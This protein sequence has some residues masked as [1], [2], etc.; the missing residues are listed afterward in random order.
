MSAF[1]KWALW[2]FMVFLLSSIAIASIESE[3]NT[4]LG[5]SIIPEIKRATLNESGMSLTYETAAGTQP[6]VMSEQGVKLDL[7]P[8]HTPPKI[9]DSRNLFDFRNV[10][11][12]IAWP[13]LSVVLNNSYGT[14]DF[15]QTLDFTHRDFFDLDNHVNLSFNHVE[16]D[17]ILLP[18]FNASSHITIKGLSFS[19]FRI[20]KDGTD[21][22][23]CSLLSVSGSDV[24][25]SAPGFSVYSIT[26]GSIMPAI[27]ISMRVTAENASVNIT[28]AI[29]NNS[30]PTNISLGIGG[31]NILNYTGVLNTTTVFTNA[32]FASALNSLIASGC[33]CESCTLSNNNL[34]C[35]ISM[36]ATSET[37]G[38]LLFADLNITQDIQNAS[39]FHAVNYT[40]IDL[41]DYFY[42]Y[43]A[44]NL[45]YNYTGGK[46]LTVTIENGTVVL[47]A[48][49]TFNDVETAFNDTIVFTASDG[50]NV[51]ESNN[52]TIFVSRTITCGNGVI[53][54]GELCDSSV[55]C[56][57]GS[58]SGTCNACVPI[59]SGGG[60]GGTGVSRPPTI[61]ITPPEQPN[62][63]APR[64]PVIEKPKPAP[65]VEQPR[66]FTSVQIITP[67]IIVAP[68]CAIPNSIYW[69]AMLITAIV[70]ILTAVMIFFTRQRVFVLAALIMGALAIA[71]MVLTEGVCVR[72]SNLWILIAGATIVALASLLRKRPPMPTV[73]EPSTQEV[74]AKAVPEHAELIEPKRPVPIR[75]PVL[76]MPPK[77]QPTKQELDTFL[78]KAPVEIIKKQPPMPKVPELSAEEAMAKVDK[79]YADMLTQ[80]KRSHMQKLLDI[81]GRKEADVEELDTLLKEDNAKLEKF[82]EEAPKKQDIAQPIKKPPITRTQKELREINERLKKLKYTPPHVRKAK[83]RQIIDHVMTRLKAKLSKEDHQLSQ[84][85]TKIERRM[86]K[87]K[88]GA[89]SKAIKS[90]NLELSKIDKGLKKLRGKTNSVVLRSDLEDEEQQLK[91]ID[92][93]LRK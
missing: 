87:E 31:I 12:E 88:S 66:P 4:T 29:Y 93:M 43:E 32:S 72:A 52:I 76:D 64:L 15:T 6:Q 60:G 55:G 63:T 46:N 51:T 1:M 56:T 77:I 20:L 85:D 10:S 73:P 79:A 47:G 61:I 91:R 25:F 2:I 35:T 75:V 23:S 53:E 59:S 38:E 92:R 86:A 57:S 36:N 49:Y 42:D 80:R 69:I 44:D 21:C 13:V 5:Y 14:V 54:P 3:Q 82:K 17:G 18:E 9:N 34:T 26:N 8:V 16:I 7:T 83:P 70:I 11:G 65:E 58:C 84:I 27:R 62:A 37:S 19:T 30:Y 89:V 81:L 24:T 78:K 45:T 68:F 50:L 33:A 48:N 74:A 71:L 39:F 90:E 28:G 40:L 22:A 41:D 67:E